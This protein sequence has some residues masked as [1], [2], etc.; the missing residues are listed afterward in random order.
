MNELIISTVV[1]FHDAILKIIV[2]TSYFFNLL[3]SKVR[4]KQTT[5]FRGGEKLIMWTIVS[6]I[7]EMSVELDLV[8][9]S[10]YAA[11]F[12]SRA[13]FIPFA[14]KFGDFRR[15]RELL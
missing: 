3:R 9:S 8:E 14:Q 15:T 1:G 12:C 5:L 7:E 13:G 2:D 10:S 4:E 11:V 6:F